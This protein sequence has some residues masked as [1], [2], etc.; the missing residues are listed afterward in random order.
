MNFQRCILG[1]HVSVEK[2]MHGLLEV[3]SFF[4]EPRSTCKSPNWLFLDDVDV[5]P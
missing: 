3:A 1:F 5:F 4:L 2:R